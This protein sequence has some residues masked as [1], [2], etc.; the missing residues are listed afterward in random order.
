M[1]S[2]VNIHFTKVVIRNEKI[3]NTCAKGLELPSSIS[4]NCDYA[5]GTMVLHKPWSVKNPLDEI[6][7]DKQQTVDMIKEMVVGREVY[8]YMYCPSTIVL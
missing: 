3:L 2:S 4:V 5:R 1:V 8:P 7:E 6:L